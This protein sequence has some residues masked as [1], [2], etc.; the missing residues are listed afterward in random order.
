M[1][2]TYHTTI[3]G[4]S[5]GVQTCDVMRAALLIL[6]YSADWWYWATVVCVLHSSRNFSLIYY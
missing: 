1:L 5:D 2:N 3:V 4:L 6:G